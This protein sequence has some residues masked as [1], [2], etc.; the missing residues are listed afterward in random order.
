LRHKY[1][2]ISKNLTFSFKNILQK[3]TESFSEPPC[4]QTRTNKKFFLRSEKKF[5][6]SHFYLKQCAVVIF[7]YKGLLPHHILAVVT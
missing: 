4:T 3:Q 1:I 5:D 6:R 2:D 7:Y